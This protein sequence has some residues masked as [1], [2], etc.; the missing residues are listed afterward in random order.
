MTHD[1]ACLFAAR[2][3]CAGIPYL[4]LRIP[5]TSIYG[6]LEPSSTCLVPL[7]AG[8]MTV[9]R[10]P[11]VRP[12]CDCGGSVH[13]RRHTRFIGARDEC[14]SWVRNVLKGESSRRVKR[15]CGLSRRVYILWGKMGII[16]HTGG[17]KGHDAGIRES[18]ACRSTVRSGGW[19]GAMPA[20]VGSVSRECVVRLLRRRS[21]PGRPRAGP[22]G[23]LPARA[24]PLRLARTIRAGAACA[25]AICPR[26]AAP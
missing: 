10:H 1:S 17:T 25:P 23:P 18:G 16:R 4:V 8:K 12:A 6:V 20:I 15:R 19:H 11:H 26:R 9:R 24:P 5:G 2:S 14:G 22:R 13:K 7:L 3:S 21:A